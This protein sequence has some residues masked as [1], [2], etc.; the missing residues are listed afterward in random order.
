MNDN[1]TIKKQLNNLLICEVSPGTNLTSAI[2]TSISMIG[3][4]SGIDDT[5]I[6]TVRFN[7]NGVELTIDENSS[8][9]NAKQMFL[10]KSKEK[11]DAYNQSEAG[12]AI[13]R[14]YEEQQKSFKSQ[15]TILLNSFD[16]ALKSEIKLI[17]WIGEF[18][19][20]TDSTTIEYDRKAFA[21]KFEEHGYNYKIVGQDEV[22]ALDEKTKLGQNILA[23]TYIALNKNENV[24]P[25]ASNFAKKYEEMLFDFEI[26]SKKNSARQ[27]IEKLRTSSIGIF[28]QSSPQ[29]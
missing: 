18:S 8:I 22:S 11:A 19:L 24:H 10:Q 20:I 16:E 13:A 5:V 28:S 23:N 12:M 21:K 4:K 14:E 27:D 6:N 25:I 2:V 3:Q 17:K 1:L 9:S 15:G 29:P 7:F 26:E